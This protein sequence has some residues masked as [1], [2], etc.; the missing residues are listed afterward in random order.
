MILG[1]LASAALGA[2][3]A[4]PPAAP[5]PGQPV[6]RMAVREMGRFDIP[7]EL[8]PAVIP[9]MLCLDASHGIEV[10]AHGRTVPPPP[11]ISRG[12]DCSSYRSRAARQGDRLLRRAGVRGRDER[13]ARVEAVLSGAERFTASNDPD[14]VQPRLDAGVEGKPG[15]DQ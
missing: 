4:E 10:R 1:L 7:D 9:Y 2:L 11:G 12:S 13:R 3:Q 14:A 8:V 15:G 5:E 6:T